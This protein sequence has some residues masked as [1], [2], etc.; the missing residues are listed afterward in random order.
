MSKRVKKIMKKMKKRINNPKYGH[1]HIRK[2]LV[3]WLLWSC[4]ILLASTFGNAYAD[5]NSFLQSKLTQHYQ[6]N[7]LET[8]SQDMMSEVLKTIESVQKLEVKY[9]EIVNEELNE[10]LGK[11]SK[12]EIAEKMSVVDKKIKEISYQDLLDDEVTKEKFAQLSALK[13]VLQAQYDKNHYT[14]N[15]NL[16]QLLASE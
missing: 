4:G 13:Y 16:E 12:W 14:K 15:V 1:F 2:S 9:I 5:H 3:I 10:K 8:K 6:Q 11:L 7:T